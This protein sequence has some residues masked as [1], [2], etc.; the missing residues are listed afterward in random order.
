MPFNNPCP[1]FNSTLTTALVGRDWLCTPYA[2]SHG[3]FNETRL[4]ISSNGF[5]V[6]SQSCC[7]LVILIYL[8][9]H[10]PIRSERSKFHFGLG[11]PDNI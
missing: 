4:W 2:Q 6:L 9:S 11:K 3:M 1:I 10:T 5:S 7:L 8:F